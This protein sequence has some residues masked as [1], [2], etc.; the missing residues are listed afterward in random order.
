MYCFPQ[1]KLLH[2]KEAFVVLGQLDNYIKKMN[3][4][5]KIISLIYL[6][7]FPQTLNFLLCID[8]YSLL[9]MLW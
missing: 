7:V 9:T 6:F 5:I 2:K 1:Y 8:V 4:Y 3:L